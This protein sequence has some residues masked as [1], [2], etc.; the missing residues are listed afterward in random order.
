VPIRCTLTLSES[1]FGHFLPRLRAWLPAAWCPEIGM[2]SP[3]FRV[4]FSAP[5]ASPILGDAP[6]FPLAFHPSSLP[7]SSFPT[8][9][10]TGT[11]RGAAV[12]TSC[13]GGRGKWLYQRSEAPPEAGVQ[14]ACPPLPQLLVPAPGICN[15]PAAGMHLTVQA[16]GPSLPCCMGHAWAM[17][18]PCMGLHACMPGP[19]GTQ[20]E[21]PCQPG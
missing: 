13:F 19:H 9:S 7:P 10:A 15:P 12:A 11:D 1:D 8:S 20:R 21:D 18:G 3:S 6:F 17:H 4:T 2:A 14:A 5:W 16:A